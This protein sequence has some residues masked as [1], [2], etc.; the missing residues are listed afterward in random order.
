[1]DNGE[2]PE[3]WS[4]SSIDDA[5]QLSGGGRPN[6]GQSSYWGG[7]VPW[8]SSG[9]IKTHRLSVGSEFIT[10][11]GLANSSAKLCPK[12]SVILVVRSGILK[13]TLPVAVLEQPAAI[14]QDLRCI[15]SGN[16]ELN[17]WLA[18]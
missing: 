1:M 16:S 7:K 11:E 3:G 18:L 10:Q 5:F 4:L 13:H 6:R 9:D 12:G 15:D 17:A 14:N 8:L 2:L